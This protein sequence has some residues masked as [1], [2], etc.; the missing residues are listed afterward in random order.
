MGGRNIFFL[1]ASLLITFYVLIS[2]IIGTLYT[3]FI[4]NLII[5]CKLILLTK[6]IIPD[7]SMYQYLLLATLLFCLRNLLFLSPDLIIRCKLI[8]GTPTPFI[9]NLF[10]LVN[11]IFLFLLSMIQISCCITHYSRHS[12]Y[13]S[14]STDLIVLFLLPTLLFYS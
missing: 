14:Y 12:I 10:I 3:T 9:S 13:Q 1:A 6:Y 5:R 8:I 2:F 4:P 7:I 11:K